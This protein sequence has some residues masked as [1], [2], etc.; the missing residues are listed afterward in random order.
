DERGDPQ[1]RLLLAD[2]KPRL[3]LLIEAVLGR[4]VAIRVAEPPAPVSWVARRLRRDIL[5]HTCPL[6]LPANDGQAIY[7]PAAIDAGPDH[8]ALEYPLLALLQALRCAR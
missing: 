7:L 3:A 8:T 6:A 1:P 2:C 4:R 5:A